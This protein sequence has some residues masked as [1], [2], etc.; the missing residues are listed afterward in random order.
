MTLDTQAIRALVDGYQKTA[1]TPHHRAEL[2]GQ[3]APHVPALL[4]ENERLARRMRVL[5]DA[6]RITHQVKP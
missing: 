6:I 5:E 3:I 1:L 2:A 4:A